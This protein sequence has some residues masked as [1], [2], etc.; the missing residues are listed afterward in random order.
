MR[1]ETASIHL[2]ELES[3]GAVITPVFLTSTFEIDKGRYVYSRV[4]NPTVEVAEKKIAF[5]EKGE[6]A[7]MFSSGMGAISTT[8]L[9]LV[10]KG[11]TIVTHR[12]LYGGTVRFLELLSEY[13]IHVSFCEVDHLKE[14]CDNADLVFMESITNPLVRV[15]DLEGVVKNSSGLVVVDNTL[16]SPYNFNPLE[17]GA[18]IVIHSATKYLGGHSDIISGVAVGEERII[19]RVRERRKLFGTNPDPFSAFLLNRSVKTLSVRMEVHNRNG[20]IIAEFLNEHE[21]VKK[22]HYPSLDTHPDRKRAERLMK[23]YGGLLSFELEGGYESAKRFINSLRIIKN[24][25]SLG[26]VESLATIPS[27]IISRGLDTGVPKGLIR[28]SAGIE[29]SDDLIEDI[30][31]ALK[32]IK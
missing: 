32:G 15:P 4:S 26:G 25:V 2:G 21:M 22:V 23:G 5:L 31:N 29:N 11:D 7:V 30:E 12:D 1:F 27:E 19:S 9:S 6:S 14:R 13:G 10:K 28:I 3:E 8:I 24:A 16:A 17:H 20:R 18:D